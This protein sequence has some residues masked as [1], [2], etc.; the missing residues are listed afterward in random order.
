MSHKKIIKMSSSPIQKIANR[1]LSSSPIKSKLTAPHVTSTYENCPV[2]DPNI[3]IISENDHRVGLCLCKFCE[4][5]QHICPNPLSKDLYPNSTYMSKYKEDFKKAS[6]SLSLK[7]IPIS[8][9]P[10]ELKMDLRTTNQEDYKPFSVSPA[11]TKDLEW[12]AK[13]NIKSPARSAYAHDFVNWGP[14]HIQIEKRFHPP[15]RSSEIPFKGQSSY[16]NN[17]YPINKETADL[18]WTNGSE[19]NAAGSKIVLGQK[20][21]S[22]FQTTYGDNMQDYS[23]NELNRLISVKPVSQEIFISIPGNFTTTSKNYYQ[24]S[25]PESKDPRTVRL[26]LYKKLKK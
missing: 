23:K 7:P 9:R 19:L 6:F 10:N 17:F 13:S 5:G 3:G 26:A 8:Y 22:M 25:F 14:T 1:A 20:E 16:N 4:C 24:G 18:Y 2:S 21:R 11:K 15:F 12:P